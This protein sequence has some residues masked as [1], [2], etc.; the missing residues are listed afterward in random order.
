MFRNFRILALSLA[1]G[2]GLV[3]GSI[4]TRTAEAAVPKRAREAA[5]ENDGAYRART[6]RLELYLPPSFA[7][8]NGAYDVVFHFHGLSRAQ[9]SNA[10]KAGLN[11]AIVSIN[12][13]VSSDKYEQRFRDPRSF[14]RLLATTERLVSAS[15][16]A[17]G[18]IVGR[19][20]LSAWSAGFASVSAILKQDAARSKV[21][22]VLLADG[23]HAAYA[24]KAHH[25][26][27]ERSLAKY[28]RLSAQAMH[29]DKLFVLTHSSIPTY[30]YANVTE[31]I[32]T[33]LRLASVDKEP[34]PASAP[35]SMQPI[36]QVNRGDFHVTGFE[37]RG[38]KDHCD[39][40]WAMG[41]TMYPL[42]AKRWRPAST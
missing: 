18:A 11:A 41:D 12:I 26:V 16:R 15:K 9:E 7:P 10:T 5:A 8:V 1:L 40:I 3:A 42:L 6:G 29:G 2:A 19:V 21:D 36:Y 33:L 23:L 20:A 39:H 32:G 14:E 38:V 34:P 30:G 27:D 31:T 4:P 35:R 28:A 24:D 17:T 22:A 13:G 37:G 25:V